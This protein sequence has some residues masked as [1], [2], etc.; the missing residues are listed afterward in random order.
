MESYVQRDAYEK[1]LQW[2][3]ENAGTTAMLIEGA[4]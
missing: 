2:K 1:L 4:R 3:R